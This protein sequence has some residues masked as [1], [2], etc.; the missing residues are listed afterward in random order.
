MTV[1][2][3]IKTL[4]FIVVIAFALNSAFPNL[5]TKKLVGG[6]V[7][8]CVGVPVIYI[9]LGLILGIV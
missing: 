1:W 9:V 4:G 7:F 8:V 3:L 5:S 6:V 2:D